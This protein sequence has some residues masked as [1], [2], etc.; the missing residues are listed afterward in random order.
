MERRVELRLVEVKRQRV[1]PR[2]LILCYFRKRR[3][4]LLGQYNQPSTSMARILHK[5]NVSGIGQKLCVP[6]RDLTREPEF[7]TDLGRRFSACTDGGHDLPTCGTDRVVVRDGGAGIQQDD[8]YL[9]DL[10]NDFSQSAARRS[11]SLGLG[12]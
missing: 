3:M 12:G 9:E 6:K 7:A 4:A 1:R 11:V 5:S 10:K 8:V 2:D